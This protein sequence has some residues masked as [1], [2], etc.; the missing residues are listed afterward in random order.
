MNTISTKPVVVDMDSHVLE[1]PDLWEEYI[2]PRY[3]DRS[4]HVRKNENGIEELI[5]DNKPL[6]QGRLAVLGGVDHQADELFMKPEIPYLEGCPKASYDTD[7]RVALLD[8]WGV[9]AGVVFLMS[10]RFRP[11]PKDTNP[12]LITIMK[13]PAQFIALSE[14]AISLVFHNRLER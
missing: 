4:I 1:P 5:V 6:L 3:R 14:K 9:D 13:S 8:E 2:E 11:D 7:A 10:T 12:A